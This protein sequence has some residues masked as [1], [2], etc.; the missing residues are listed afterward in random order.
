MFLRE[1]IKA[2]GIT[3][4][5]CVAITYEVIIPADTFVF[6]PLDLHSL[7]TSSYSARHRGNIDR[8]HPYKSS[9][10]HHPRGQEGISYT[11]NPDVERTL[12]K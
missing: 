11:S 1:P 12:F 5:E 4:P 7:F 10:G 9:R 2:V 3:S 8:S 6:K